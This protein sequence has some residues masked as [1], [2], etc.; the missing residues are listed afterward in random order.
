MNLEG[1]GPEKAPLLPRGEEL[2]KAKKDGPYHGNQT[3]QETEP[4]LPLLVPTVDVSK[5]MWLDELK[6]NVLDKQYSIVVIGQPPV[7]DRLGLKLAL[8][9]TS[10]GKLHTC[11]LIWKMG[12]ITALTT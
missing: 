11:F 3:R 8:R 7:P 1:L 6:S 2:R 9:L 12:V 10:W 5:E 4:S